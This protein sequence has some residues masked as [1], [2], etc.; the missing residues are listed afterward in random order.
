MN[1]DFDISV[2]STGTETWETETKN[3]REPAGTNI[4]GYGSYG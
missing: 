1:T 4:K 3:A 2:I